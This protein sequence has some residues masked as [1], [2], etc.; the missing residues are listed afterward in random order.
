MS[1]LLGGGFGLGSLL[2]GSG[3]HDS[4]LTADVWHNL[5]TVVKDQTR[6]GHKHACQHSNLAWGPPWP[7]AI[8][9][10]P[11]TEDHTKRQRQAA[12]CRKEALYSCFIGYDGWI[13]VAGSHCFS[14]HT[15]TNTI[16]PLSRPAAI[17]YLH[18]MYTYIMECIKML[19][20]SASARRHGNLL[21]GNPL[22]AKSMAVTGCGSSSGVSARSHPLTAEGRVHTHT[23]ITTRRRVELCICVQSI[24]CVCV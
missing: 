10:Q 8:F 3:I 24:L 7:L 6:G 20:P 4:R 9:S 17:R 19:R 13:L 15:L 18:T 22:G 2:G 11:E 5:D 12:E 23:Y 21:P 1:K 16:S 14:M